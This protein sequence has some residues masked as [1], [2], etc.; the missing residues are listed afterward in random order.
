MNRLI[1]LDTNITSTFLKIDRF[2]LLFDLSN[3]QQFFISTNVFAELEE[4]ELLGY[5][6]VKPIFQLIENGQIAVLS[7]TIEETKWSFQLSSSFGREE[8]DSIA[9]CKF[10][11]GIFFTNERKVRR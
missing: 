3:N 8:R 4:A 11:N 10:R 6:F 1:L 2:Q 5:D 7:M 9:I